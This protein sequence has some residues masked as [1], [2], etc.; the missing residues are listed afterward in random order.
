MTQNREGGSPPPKKKVLFQV[1][2]CLI[3]FCSWKG[4]F[5]LLACLVFNAECSSSN[6]NKIHLF[7]ELQAIS[8][9]IDA[10]SCGHAQG[11][12]TCY[13]ESSSS[14]V[15]STMSYICARCFRPNAIIS[16]HILGFTITVSF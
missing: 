3:R 14:T 12:C 4:I 7:Q 8:C 16:E 9:P 13:F 11:P 15:D 1:C 2:N 6:D 10:H 5:Y